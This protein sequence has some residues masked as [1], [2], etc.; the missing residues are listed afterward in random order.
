MN[1]I[2]IKIIITESWFIL[3]DSKSNNNINNSLILD[4]ILI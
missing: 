3:I 2:I 1:E 4:N